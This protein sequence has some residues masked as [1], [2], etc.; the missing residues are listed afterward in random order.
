MYY[1]LPEGISEKS[2]NNTIENFKFSIV[3]SGTR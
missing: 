2:E 1:V 3:S